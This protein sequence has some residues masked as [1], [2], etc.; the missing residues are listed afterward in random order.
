[1]KIKTLATLS[2]SA[3][4]VLGVNSIYAGSTEDGLSCVENALHAA[5]H[6]ADE[7][8]S[9][10]SGGHNTATLNALEVQ[11]NGFVKG[12]NASNAKDGLVYSKFGSQQGGQ[13][14]IFVAYM[15]SNCG[16]ASDTKLFCNLKAY[17]TNSSSNVNFAT[18]TVLTNISPSS[19]HM[20]CKVCTGVELNAAGAEVAETA[21]VGF[22][23]TDVATEAQALTTIL[24]TAQRYGNELVGTTTAWAGPSPGPAACNEVNFS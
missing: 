16:P 4:A 18:N 22:S 1:M 14:Y 24:Q 2:L 20:S 23:T 21:D 7:I 15:G 10:Y 6:A 8:K 11:Y 3:V 5:S 13:N 19:M 17:N 9:L 12:T